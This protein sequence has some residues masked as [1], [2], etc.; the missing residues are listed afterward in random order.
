[1]H[2]RLRHT[3][4]GHRAAI[5]ALAPS[6][7]ER[8][9]LSAGGDG[10]I[11]EWDADNPDIGQVMAT[12]PERIFSLHCPPVP[13]RALA[14]NMN[15][16]LHWIDWGDPARSRDVQHHRK[17]IFDIA[18]RDAQVLT[19]G[20]DG[21]LTRWDAQQARSLE[22][23]QLGAQPLRCIAPSPDG[24]RWAV[25]SSDGSISL[26]D[27]DT[28][29]VLGQKEKAHQSS[30]FCALWV[31]HRL[32]TGGRDAMLRSW[33]LSSGTADA[34]PTWQMQA[35]LP[36]HWF[37]I[38]HLTLSPGGK[39]LASASRDKTIKIWH[40]HSLELLRVVDVQRYGGHINSVNRLLW[41]SDHEWVSCSDDRTLKWWEIR[42]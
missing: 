19:A 41:L 40:P 34:P 11:V 37:T 6:P 36:A 13:G 24:S 15:G 2:I 3:S 27:A 7:T 25:G 28:L 23:V 32:L 42:E 4:T 26:I 20:G 35:E 33:H 10:W 18:Q 39:W 14:G 30:V 8:R 9:I 29:A 22:S 31:G 5:Y 1:M 17:G 16:G 38:N 12:V 21:L